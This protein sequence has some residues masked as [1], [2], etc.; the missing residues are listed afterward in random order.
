MEV[1]IRGG[2]DTPA[3]IQGKDVCFPWNSGSPW[4]AESQQKEAGER[5][6]L[7]QGV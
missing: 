1:I 7:L 5:G 6:V 2:A 3:L 4:E